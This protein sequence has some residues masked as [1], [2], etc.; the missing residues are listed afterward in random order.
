MTPAV[1]LYDLKCCHCGPHIMT[2][3]L[4]K[5]LLQLRC[6]PAIGTTPQSG[7]QSQVGAVCSGR[8]AEPLPPDSQEHGRKA[9]R[10]ADGGMSWAF[11]S[12]RFQ[13]R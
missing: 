7:K 3:V 2:D 8:A 10:S 9:E 13:I 4:L 12:V 6:S 11:G 1:G 5:A